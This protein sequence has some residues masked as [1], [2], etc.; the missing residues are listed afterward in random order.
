MSTKYYQKAKQNSKEKLEK[1]P[2]AFSENKRKER[3]Y[4]RERYQNLSEEKKKQ[5][6]GFK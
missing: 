6:Y 3:Q 4:A 1:V 5:Q 2:R